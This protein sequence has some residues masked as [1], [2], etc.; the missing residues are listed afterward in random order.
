MVTPIT[1]VLR[2]AAAPPAHS[3]VATAAPVRPT[4]PVAAPKD[5]VKLSAD[6]QVHLLRNQGQTPNQIAVT[7]DLSPQ[8]VASYLGTT[9]LQLPALSS[10]K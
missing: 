9:P 1:R 8:L 6:A 3:P 4:V 10:T 2:E 7:L 5:T